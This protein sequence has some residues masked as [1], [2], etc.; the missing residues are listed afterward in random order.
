MS[1]LIEVSLLSGRTVSLEAGPG[2]AVD[3]LLAF[4]WLALR[5]LIFWVFVETTIRSQKLNPTLNP[6]P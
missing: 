3:S 4:F 6:R 5:I 1:F 2:E